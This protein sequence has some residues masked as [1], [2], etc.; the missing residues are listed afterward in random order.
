MSSHNIFVYKY[1]HNILLPKGVID[2][3]S[4]LFKVWQDSMI[5][6]TIFHKELF[7]YSKELANSPFTRLWVVFRVPKKLHA[8]I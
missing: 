2:Q 6:G 4:N 8:C 5:N 7:N 1:F 3:M